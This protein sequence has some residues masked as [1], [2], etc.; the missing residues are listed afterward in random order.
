MRLIVINL[1]AVALL[2]FSAGTASAILFTLD[3]LDGQSLT[4]GGQVTVTVE[5]DT[6]TTVGITVMSSGVLFD[7]TKLTY[8]PGASQ[9]TS[10]LLYGGRG[11]G[12]FLKAAQTCGGYPSPGGQ[13]TNS[14]SCQLALPGQINVDYVSA[15]LSNGTQNT[16]MSMLVTLVFDVIASADDG[17]DLIWQ[18]ATA[19]GNVVGQPG[20]EK[21]FP[22][23]GG[24]AL[25]G[26][27][28]VMA[29]DHTIVPEPAMASLALAAILTVGGL[30]RRERRRI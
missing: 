7:D 1:L 18:T 12:G 8:N 20:G 26:T 22:S 25:D 16:G 10:Y 14:G 6:E 27:G 13:G 15:D 4:P 30:R 24:K 11:G 9:A 28:G 29:F 5:L 2:S 19:P 17:T 23:L 21:T 3:G